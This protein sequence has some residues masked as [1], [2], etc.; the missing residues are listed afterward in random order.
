LVRS[1]TW[2]FDT[3]Q[4][5][6][7]DIC[8]TAPELPKEGVPH[9]LP[10]TNPFT[11]EFAE[12][13]GLPFEGTRGGAETIYPEFRLKMSKPAKVPEKCSRYCGCG[14]DGRGCSLR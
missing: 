9:Y 12:L 11:H 3:Q 5:L 7:R 6:G 1:Q 8:T 2:V 4:R 14:Q 13:Y 10:N